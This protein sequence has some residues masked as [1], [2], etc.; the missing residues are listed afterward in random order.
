MKR[1]KNEE[2]EERHLSGQAQSAGRGRALAH[3]RHVARV[4]L[5][6]REGCGVECLGCRGEGV[7]FRV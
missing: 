3:D 6:C 2:R 5:V 4:D 1:E 7:G